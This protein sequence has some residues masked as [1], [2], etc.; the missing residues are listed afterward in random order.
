MRRLNPFPL[1]YQVKKEI[2]DYLIENDYQVGDQIPTEKEFVDFLG[3]T[4]F[5]LREGLNLLE[6]ERIIST[7]HGVGRYLISKPN[8]ISIDITSLQSIPDLLAGFNIESV[9][10]ILHL[11]EIP[12]AGE[13]SHH[14]EI[15]DGT[16]VIS[17]ERIR[18]AKIAPIIYSID[19]FP[20]SILPPGWKK[21]DFKGSLFKYIETICKI[22][23]S[24][25][26][27]TVRAAFLP[28]EIR[29]K[30]TGLT[31]PWILMEQVICSRDGKPIIYSKDYHSDHIS[32]SVRRFKLL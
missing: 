6:L 2:L 28:E 30:I 27:A 19:S 17:I 8:N 5:S 23:L 21:Q 13:L 16:P 7:K 3:V 12:A 20:K 10:K 1:R 22:E 32:F 14:L 29:Q 18:Y 15:E 31:S 9:D 24:Y 26:Q 25:S 11:Q 4:R